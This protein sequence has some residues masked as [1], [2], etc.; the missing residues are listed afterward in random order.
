MLNDCY[1]SRELAHNLDYN[2]TGACNARMTIGQPFY[3]DDMRQT[4]TRWLTPVERPSSISISQ[5]TS[6]FAYT[7]G[8]IYKDP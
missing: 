8:I 1:S 4:S 2:L 3:A 6:V 7:R 5:R